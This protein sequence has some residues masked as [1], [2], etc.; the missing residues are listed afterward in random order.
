MSTRG[1]NA[2]SLS[3]PLPRIYPPSGT[4][5]RAGERGLAPRVVQHRAP[6]R[7][8]EIIRISAN[9]AC[10]QSDQTKSTCL[11]KIISDLERSL[12]TTVRLGSEESRGKDPTLKYSVTMFIVTGVKRL[13]DSRM[14]TLSWFKQILQLLTSS[15]EERMDLTTAMWNLAQMIPAEILYMTGDLLPAM[16]SLDPQMSKN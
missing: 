7:P 12:A 10:Q 14:L 8:R 9:H 15:M 11:L 1:W 6:I 16:V 5:L 13:R 4:P 2:S 3:K